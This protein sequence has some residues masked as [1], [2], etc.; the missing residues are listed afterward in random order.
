M[1]ES[2]VLWHQ[3]ARE[4]PTYDDFRVQLGCHLEE[5]VEQLDELKLQ[6]LNAQNKLANALDLLE[7]V[8][9]GLKCKAY[10]VD[11]LDKRNFLKELCDGVVTAAG[12]AHCSNM[13]FYSAME[14]VNRSNWSKF[15]YKGYPEFDKQGKIKKGDTYSPAD[16][17]GMV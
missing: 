5:I 6:D 8:S 10:D 3:R 4:T 13:S 11:I 7:D 2:I 17:N 9:R 16:L 15:N 12:V 1:I 14:E